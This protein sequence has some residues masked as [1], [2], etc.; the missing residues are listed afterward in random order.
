[1]NKALLAKNVWRF[2]QLNSGLAGNWV[3]NGYSSSSNDLSFKCKAMSSFIWKGFLKNADLIMNLLK[4][5][6][7]N[8]CSIDITSRRWVLPWDC[9][10]GLFN[11]ADLWDSTTCSWNLNFIQGMYGNRDVNLLSNVHLSS[12]GLQDNLVWNG[13]S[14]GNYTVAQ[15]YKW[16]LS[17]R[18]H[19]TF[20]RLQPS[21]F[22]WKDFW[23]SKLPHRVLIL[24]WRILWDALPTMVTLQQHHVNTSQHGLCLFC[25]QHEETT[26]H[27]LL[28]CP[29][30]K[31]VW[32]GLSQGLVEST[33]GHSIKS[34]IRM[35]VDKWRSSK[36]EFEEAWIIILITIDAL[37]FYRNKCL[38]KGVIPSPLAVINE[39][40]CRKKIYEKSWQ[41]ESLLVAKTGTDNRVNCGHKEKLQIHSHIVPL[42]WLFLQMVKNNHRCWIFAIKRQSERQWNIW[43]T[44]QTSKVHSDGSLFRLL[45]LKDFLLHLLND[46]LS[47][48]LCNMSDVVY[49]LGPKVCNV[50]LQSVAYDINVILGGAV[51]KYSNC[52]RLMSQLIGLQAIRKCLLKPHLSCLTMYM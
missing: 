44:P 31:A 32:F 35:W 41:Q 36:D 45:F 1:M 39:I 21:A 5:R 13:H 19:V 48:I 18:A 38:W 46:N 7:G 14:S 50:L 9:P 6:P 15:G 16:L 52:P 17:N 12:F 34:W 49:S 25:G 8:G 51:V 43:L 2:T 11:V 4:W 42:D 20:N 24:V 30:T 22:P 29:F 28:T 23:R 27:V 3:R 40:S 26:D 37:W 47:T 33:A 10:P